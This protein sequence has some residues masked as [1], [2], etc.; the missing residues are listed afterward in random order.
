MG[1]DRPKGGRIL[2]W[3]ETAARHAYPIKYRNEVLKVKKKG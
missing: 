2:D 3:I 1:G